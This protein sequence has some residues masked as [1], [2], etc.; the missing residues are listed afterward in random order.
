MGNKRSYAPGRPVPTELQEITER[1]LQEKPDDRYQSAE[2][3][4]EDLG[5]YLHTAAYSLQAA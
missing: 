4:A 1:A 2:E 3:M 5:R